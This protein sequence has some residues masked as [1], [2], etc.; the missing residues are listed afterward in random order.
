MERRKWWLI[1]VIV[2]LLVIGALIALSGTS[3]V[4][5]FVYTVF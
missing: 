4:A 1:P 3:G 5:P 2:V